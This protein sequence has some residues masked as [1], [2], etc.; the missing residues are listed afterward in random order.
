MNG[1]KELISEFAIASLVIAILSFVN[2][3]GLEKAIVAIVFGVLALRKIEDTQLKSKKLA[4]A[5]IILGIISTLLTITFIIKF[6][7]KIQ[8]RLKQIQSEEN[9]IVPK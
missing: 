9:R 6:Y 8:Q 4:N 1:Q 2:L 5:G 3:A 7:P